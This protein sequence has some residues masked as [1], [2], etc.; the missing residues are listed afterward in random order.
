MEG[1]LRIVCLSKR[2]IV[3]AQ[4]AS[5]EETSVNRTKLGITCDHLQRSLLIERQ[6]P[7]GRAIAIPSGAFASAA[8]GLSG[9]AVIWAAQQAVGSTG[10]DTAWGVL[11]CLASVLCFAAYQLAA[12]CCGEAARAAAGLPGLRAQLLQ[13]GAVGLVATV[14][15]CADRLA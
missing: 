3:Q 8:S 2:N 5:Q 1:D 10:R 13:V 15:I 7:H 14:P 12:D 4:V 11:Q 6:R 9:L